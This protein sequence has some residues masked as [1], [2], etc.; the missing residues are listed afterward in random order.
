M[1]I[2]LLSLIINISLGKVDKECVDWF[3]KSKIKPGSGCFFHCNAIPVIPKT[4]LCP[5]FC[6]DLCQLTFTE[7]LLFNLSDLYPG[8]T[9]QERALAAEEPKKTLKA[10]KLALKAEEICKVDYPTS[11]T[12]D[13]SDAC[14]HFVWAALLN[15]ELGEEFSKKVLDAHEQNKSQPEREKVMDTLNNQRGLAASKKL[16]TDKNFD[17]KSIMS[18]FREELKSGKVSI[19]KGSKK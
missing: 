8:L 11:D 7:G 19:L 17:E 4:D 18:K 9:S 13:A 3:S 5:L 12:N 10:F 1:F 16:L 6:E 14:R 15:Q 2:F